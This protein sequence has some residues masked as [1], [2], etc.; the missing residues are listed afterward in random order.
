MPQ[1]DAQRLERLMR[2]HAQGKISDAQLIAAQEEMLGGG[3]GARQEPFSAEQAADAAGG[4]GKRANPLDD[5]R[6]GVEEILGS[7]RSGQ[8]QQQG[9]P[10]GQYG[11]RRQQQEPQPSMDGVPPDAQPE[12]AENEKSGGGQVATQFITFIVV[13]AAIALIRRFTG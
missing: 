13:A 6:S 4:S 2:R 11:D 12:E 1:S 7:S 9:T 3:Q 5:V 8:P 10:Q